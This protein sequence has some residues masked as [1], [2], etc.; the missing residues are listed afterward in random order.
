MNSKVSSESSEAH[1][2][3]ELMF[4]STDAVYTNPLDNVMDNVP[5]VSHVLLRRLNKNLLLRNTSREYQQRLVDE[6]L[7]DN[8]PDTAAPPNVYQPGDYVTFDAG[9]KPHPKL[10]CRCKGPYCSNRIP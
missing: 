2:P 6:R 1:T 10:A 9:L 5:D 3:F 4:G 7:R 8:N